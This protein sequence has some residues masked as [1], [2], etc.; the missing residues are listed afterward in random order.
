MTGTAAALSAKLARNGARSIASMSLH[1]VRKARGLYVVLQ[2]HLQASLQRSVDHLNPSIHPWQTSALPASDPPKRIPGSCRILRSCSIG[3][4]LC[5]MKTSSGHWPSGFRLYLEISS[6]TESNESVS[7]HFAARSCLGPDLQ[8]P[9][10][11]RNRS[12]N[13]PTGAITSRN[14]AGPVLPLQ[15]VHQPTGPISPGM[16]RLLITDPRTEVPSRA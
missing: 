16:R 14:P 12:Q 8:L 10:V 3:S 1:I 13:P 7:P 4:D 5:L 2:I 15:I 11:R 9:R 6:A